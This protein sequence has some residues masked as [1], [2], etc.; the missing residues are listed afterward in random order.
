MGIWE[1]AVSVKSEPNGPMTRFTCD[2][3]EYFILVIRLP[4]AIEAEARA[5]ATMLGVPAGYGMC[6]SRFTLAC[7]AG[8]PEDTWSTF[9]GA[10]DPIL[11]LRQNFF[12]SIWQTKF[13]RIHSGTRCTIWHTDEV[14]SLGYTVSRTARSGN[15][16]MRSSKALL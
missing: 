14:K 10:A 16:C 1:S 12:S 3:R 5:N 8:E 4:C 2:G 11:N 15:C 9:I 7:C 6:D 13:R